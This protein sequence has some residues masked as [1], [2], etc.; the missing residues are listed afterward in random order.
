MIRKILVASMWAAVVMILC[1]CGKPDVRKTP[2]RTAAPA[3]GQAARLHQAGSVLSRNEGVTVKP[4]GWVA[5]PARERGLDQELLAQEALQLELDRD[6]QVTLAIGRARQQILAQAYIERAAV[7]ASKASPR[8]IRKFYE[9]N[10]AL[11]GQRRTYRVLE[12][13][14]AIPEAQFGALQDAAAGAKNIGEVVRWL[15]LRKLP[16]ETGTSSAAAEQI[17]AN[18]LLRLFG[19]RDGQIAVFKTPVGVSVVWLE[20][21]AE[22]P[23]TEKQAGPAIAR[24]LFNRK[25]LE[26]A[27]AEV[28]KLRERARTKD[29]GVERVRRADAAHAA[30]PAQSLVEAPRMARN[31]TDFTGLK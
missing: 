17:P 25:R 20:Q 29:D 28:T 14:V 26:L 21:S 9:E 15:E 2:E 24:Y 16:F 1:S 31:T 11:F 8:E 3:G 27:Q 10:P 6:G 12:L 30:G 4:A 22:A 5:V 23:L 13:M 19:M 18:T 7:S